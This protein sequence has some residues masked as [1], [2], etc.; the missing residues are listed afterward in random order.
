MHKASQKK[1]S[2][3]SCSSDRNTCHGKEALLC[4]AGYTLLELIVVLMLMSLILGLSAV[5][6]SNSLPTNRFNSATRDLAASF[7]Q[8]R[9]LARIQGEKQILTFDLDNKEYGIEG[10]K[11]KTIHPD[12]QIKIVDPVVGD[13]TEGK[14]RFIVQ[15]LGA[16]GGTIVVWDDK[17]KASITLDPVAGALTI[18]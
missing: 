12:I 15:P 9:A 3:L 16:G 5:Y 4:R 11:G 13:I 8:A 14:Y 2:C 7:R 17:R 1:R 6:F 18:R 10:R